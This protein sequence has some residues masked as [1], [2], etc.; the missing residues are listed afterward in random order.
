[1]WCTA[2][3]RLPLEEMLAL[4]Q[5]K[6]AVLLACRHI[7]RVHDFLWLAED[8]MKM[9]GYNG[10]QLWDTAFAVQAISHTG[11][12]KEFAQCLRWA[13]HYIDATQVRS[14]GGADLM[15]TVRPQ[16]RVLPACHGKARPSLRSKLQLPQRSPPLWLL[17]VGQEPPGKLVLA[18]LGAAVLPQVLDDCP[19]NL[20]EYYR[21]ISKGAWPF[22]TRDHGWPI[23]DCSS[24]GLKVSRMS[25]A[26]PAIAGALAQLG[27]A[28]RQVSAACCLC[29]GSVTG[30][31]HAFK[32]VLMQHAAC[33]LLPARPALALTG[34]CGQAKLHCHQ[35]SVQT[36]SAWPDAS[37]CRPSPPAALH[38]AAFTLARSHTLHVLQA[39]LILAKLDPALVGKPIPENRLFD[40]VNVIL[41]YQ[42]ACGGWATYENTRSYAFLE[43]SLHCSLWRPL[44]RHAHT[45]CCQASV[46]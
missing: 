8:G 29:S 46:L 24:E 9:Q 1:M 44:A 10:S 36:R 30:K 15:Q 2:A 3:G 23:S 42:N 6:R 22:S 34:C 28:G 21:H 38:H 27:P 16:F 12:E 35:P 20:T 14:R 39:A 26:S 18:A 19:G 13:H 7:P 4:L 33:C 40:C 45:L 32:S 25:L 43:V 37:H 17:H 41:S 31:L 11:L 5:L